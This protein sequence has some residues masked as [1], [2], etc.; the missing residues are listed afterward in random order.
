MYVARVELSGFDELPDPVKCG[1]ILRTVW[2][3]VEIDRAELRHARPRVPPVYTLGHLAYHY[4]DAAADTWLDV[5]R[6]L[7]VGGGSCNSLAAWRV[8][9]LREAGEDARPYVRTQTVH[10]RDGSLLD[11]FHIIVRRPLPPPHRWED[12][13]VGLGMPGPA[14]APTPSDLHAAGLVLR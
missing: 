1:L 3:L 6:V 14:Q 7:E 13:S 5:A 11:V 2:W 9:E 12:P 4:Q 8:A 10:Q